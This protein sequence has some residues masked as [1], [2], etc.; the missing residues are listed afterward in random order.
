MTTFEER[1][2]AFEA[3]YAHDEEFRFRVTARR[4]KLFAHWAAEQLHLADD[5]DLTR[6][7]LA[8]KDGAGHDERLL[9]LARQ[10]FLAHGAK[11]PTDLIMVLHQ[12]AEKARLDLLDRNP[13]WLT[14]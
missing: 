4:D 12:C 6:K 3:K 13:F 9:D 7:V 1:E 10:T 5:E 14:T 2:R 8:V 11:D